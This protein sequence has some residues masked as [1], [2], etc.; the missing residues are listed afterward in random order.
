MSSHSFITYTGQFIKVIN[1]L[2]N[3]GTKKPSNTDQTCSMT[4]GHSL[5]RQLITLQSQYVLK[6][7]ETDCVGTLNVNR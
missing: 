5:D 4:V 6:S 1:Q 7:T 3:S 2:V